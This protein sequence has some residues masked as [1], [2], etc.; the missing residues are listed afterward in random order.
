MADRP[1]ALRDFSVGGAMPRRR[2]CGC[3]FSFIMLLP[4]TSMKT[5]QNGT[6]NQSRRLC[7]NSVLPGSVGAL[8]TDHAAAGGGALPAGGGEDCTEVL[9]LSVRVLVAEGA[10]T[11]PQVGR[12]LL[13]CGERLCEV[14]RLSA[15]C[16]GC[17]WCWRCTHRR[18]ASTERLSTTRPNA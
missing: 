17:S 8:S 2:G 7:V 3:D 9:R 10:Q 14:W 11:M 6:E 16:F 4:A 13:T 12:G 5:S 15:F 1:R 18:R